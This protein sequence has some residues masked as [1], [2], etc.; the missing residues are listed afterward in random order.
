MQ[1]IALNALPGDTNTTAL[2]GLG[3]DRAGIVPGIERT[4]HNEYYES[5]PNPFGDPELR[6]VQVNALVDEDQGDEA[7]REI[8]MITGLASRDEDEPKI[9]EGLVWQSLQ[10]E[11]NPFGPRQ[12][13]IT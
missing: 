8:A 9:D 6:I 7:L 13:A 3:S 11:H 12:F 10:F 1:T 5:Q 4:E 2:S